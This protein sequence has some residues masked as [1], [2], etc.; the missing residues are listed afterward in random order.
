MIIMDILRQSYIF[1]G[2]LKKKSLEFCTNNTYTKIW[3]DD[4]IDKINDINKTLNKTQYT[5]HLQLKN[6]SIIKTIC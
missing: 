1:T 2:H 4:D 5:W 6:Q 3:T